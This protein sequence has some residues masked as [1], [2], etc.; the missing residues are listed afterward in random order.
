MY[1]SYFMQPMLFHDYDV[2]LIMCKAT[3]NT[4]QMNGIDSE[5]NWIPGAK[6]VW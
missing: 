6:G 1:Y 2:I 3:G 5:G 4:C